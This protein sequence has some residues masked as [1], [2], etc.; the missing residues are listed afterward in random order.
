MIDHDVVD[1]G[2]YKKAG[3]MDHKSPPGKRIWVEDVEGSYFDQESDESYDKSEDI[4][5]S[6]F[7]KELEES[8]PKRNVIRNLMVKIL[9]FLRRI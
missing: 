3:V 6:Y 2:R 9:S 5:N 8:T 4:E 7:N 1:K